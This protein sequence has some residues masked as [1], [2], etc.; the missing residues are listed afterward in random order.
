[1]QKQRPENNSPVIYQIPCKSCQPP[2]SYFGESIDF[3]KRKYQHQYAIRNQ[4]TNN[5]IVKHML[6]TNHNVHIN[7]SQ[8]IRRENNTNKR[9]II[10]SI[11]IYNKDNFNT[12]KS[13]YNLDS[14][15]NNLIIQNYSKLHNT[16]SLIDRNILN[17]TNDT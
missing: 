15:T 2:T 12:Q 9:K 6:D 4:D 16:F 1:M 17:L 7:D 5:A 3:N 8:I 10:E 11:I 13:N 14:F